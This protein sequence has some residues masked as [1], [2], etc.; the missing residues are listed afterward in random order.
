MTACQLFLW[1]PPGPD[2]VVSAPVELPP[3]PFG[4]A[5]EGPYKRISHVSGASCDAVNVV[6]SRDGAATRHGVFICGNNE[7]KQ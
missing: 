6:E 2:E 7:E 1:G 5:V 4:E 3:L